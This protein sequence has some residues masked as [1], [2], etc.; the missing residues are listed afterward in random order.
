MLTTILSI[1]TIGN[2]DAGW[3]EWVKSYKVLSSAD[4]VT[5]TTVLY[6][7]AYDVSLHFFFTL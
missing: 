5:F 1:T 4:G 3:D 6:T 2:A 7:D